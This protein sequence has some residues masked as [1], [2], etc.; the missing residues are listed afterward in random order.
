MLFLA[1]FRDVLGHLFKKGWE[2]KLHAGCFVCTCQTVDACQTVDEAQVQ[3]F[4][5]RFNTCVGHVSIHM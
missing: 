4:Y 3:S 1:P 5:A 2:L